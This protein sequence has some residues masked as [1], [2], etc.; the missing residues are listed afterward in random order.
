M[1]EAIYIEEY[2]MGRMGQERFKTGSG[3]RRDWS[4]AR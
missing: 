1:K 4:T 3:G 2:R